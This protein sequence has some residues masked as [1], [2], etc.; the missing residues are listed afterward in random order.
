MNVQVI[1]QI[2]SSFVALFGLGMIWFQLKQGAKLSQH[3]ALSSAHKDIISGE[4]RKALRIIFSTPD[5]DIKEFDKNVDES[6]KEAFEFVIAQYDLIGAR[7]QDKVLPWNGTLKTEW[8]ILV[9]LWPKVAPLIES[10]KEGRGIPY[11]EHFV[12]IYKQALHYQKKYYPNSLPKI[13][14]NELIR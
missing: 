14:P 11:K 6:T 4:F 13:N 9:I 5:L 3:A 8:K 1:L 10:R 12:W 2:V 7:L